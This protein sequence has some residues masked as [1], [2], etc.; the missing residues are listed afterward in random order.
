MAGLVRTCVILGLS[1]IAAFT[2]LASMG[3]PAGLSDA[4]ST[5]RLHFAFGA[6]AIALM[7][8][9]LGRVTAI[10]G[11]ALAFVNLLAG[12]HPLSPVVPPA[13]GK[14]LKVMT[15]NTLYRVENGDRII[16][17]IARH[18]PDIVFLQEQVVGKQ[19]IYERLKTRYPFQVYCRRVGECDTA[20]LSRY[21]WISAEA[22]KVGRDGASFALARFGAELN[23]LTVATVHLK[24]PQYSSQ[25]AQLARAWDHLKDSKGEIILAGDFNAVPW[26][27]TL[28]TFS[29]N[30]GLRTTGGLAATWPARH[31]R[32]GRPCLWCVPQLQIDHVL[33][34]SG[35]RV[36]AAAVGKDLGS[37]HLPV[38]VELELPMLVSRT[39]NADQFVATTCGICGAIGH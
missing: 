33:V 29:A 13:N 18:D 38:H 39:A 2:L 34:S 23:N 37:D 7:G 30:T 9:W 6:S 21:P 28:R 12:D 14:P 4:F 1:A 15:F 8:L 26:S 5:F 24:W 25:L 31:H 20:I 36:T 27:G 3:E 16:S 32:T 19:W 10:A 11:L 17:E 35:I 22:K